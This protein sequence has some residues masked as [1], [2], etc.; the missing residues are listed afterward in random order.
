MLICFFIFRYYA[1]DQLIYPADLGDFCKIISNI[2]AII[3]R[4][5]LLNLFQH[6][7]NQIVMA[8]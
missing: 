6:F 4:I 5:V 7:S 8:K 1:G 2:C 3:P